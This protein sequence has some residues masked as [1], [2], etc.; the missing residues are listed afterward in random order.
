MK[1][2]INCNLSQKLI[3]KNREAFSLIIQNKN[4]LNDN[5]EQ[6]LFNHKSS[7]ETTLNLIKNFQLDYLSK[8]TKKDKIKTTKK[9]LIS[10]RNN[11][12]FMLEEKNKKL[13]YIKNKNEISK[14][15]IQNLLFP[16]SDLENLNKIKYNI[17]FE[18]NRI[19][20][21][22]S[23][24]NQLELLNFQIEN[25]I[26]K[27]QFLIEQKTNIISYI[28]SI[29]FFFENNKEIFCKN[30]YET[31]EKITGFLNEIIRKVRKEFIEVVKEKMKLELEIN[32]IS[33]Q[34]NCIKD[35]IED[36]KLKGCKKFIESEDI[37]QEDSKEYVKSIITNQ[38]K[39]NSFSSI[40]NISIVKKM[41]SI[42][43]INSKNKYN[44]KERIIKD[45]IQNNNMFF[46][47]KINKNILNDINN[48]SVNNYLN[49]N[50]NVN[51][52]LNNNN[53]IQETFNS[54]LDS[55][56]IDEENEKNEQY[57][58][59]LND[60]NKIIITPI[61]T[62]ENISTVNNKNDNFDIKDN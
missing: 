56:N 38:S 32:G 31:I 10:F 41:S 39:R 35:D 1:G 57:E 4:I 33:L 24:K 19:Y 18:S 55:N 7:L 58:M 13:N 40:N 28:K 51:I 30:D 23:E 48:K 34:I 9:M 44:K 14:K 46:T 21:L 22:I 61:T 45:K 52:N 49:M 15:K 62:N 50:I 60:D 47:N 42:S 59:D 53:F 2:K 11:I 36:Y 16:S 26:E 29:P 25:E 5:E 6:I 3:S 12:N 37:I 17:N 8:K 27:T 54:S 43:S 20:S